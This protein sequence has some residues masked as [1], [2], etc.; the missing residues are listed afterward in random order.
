M[1]PI[2]FILVP[3]LLF[4][5]VLFWVR[6]R[7]QPWLRALVAL[8]LGTTL[9]F[10]LFPDSSTWVANLVGVGRGVDIVIYLGMVG[11]AVG[12]LLLYLRVQRLEAKLAEVGRQVALQGARPPSP[13]HDSPPQN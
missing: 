4:W 9:I 2:Q 1:R 13:P 11:L 10:T 12:L 7:A 3:L 6:L 8:V 5:L